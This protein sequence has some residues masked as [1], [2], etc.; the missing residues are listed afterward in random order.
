MYANETFRDIPNVCLGG[1]GIIVV[2]SGS[3][4]IENAY[5][6]Y[7]RIQLYYHTLLMPAFSKIP[8]DRN[9]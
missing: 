2:K 3:Q 7:S 4:V 6:Y 5:A 9:F 1:G 8:G